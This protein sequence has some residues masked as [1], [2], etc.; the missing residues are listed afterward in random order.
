MALTQAKLRPTPQMRDLATE[1]AQIDQRLPVYP[2][3]L[4]WLLMVATTI[5]GFDRSLLSTVLEDV[6]RAFDLNDGQLGLLTGAYSVLAAIS[7]LPFGILTDRV[8]RASLVAFGFVPWGLGMMWQGVAQSFAMMFA[9]RMFLGLLE[10]SNVPATVVAP[11]RLLPGARAQPHLRSG[12]DRPDRRLRRRSHPGW[13]HRVLVGMALGV[14]RL[15]PRRV[16]HGRH[17]AQVPARAA[18]W[19]AGRQVPAAEPLQGAAPRADPR[20]PRRGSAPRARARGPA[21]R[22]RPVAAPS[23]GWTTAGS[24]PSRPPPSSCAPR[25]CG[26]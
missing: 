4:M 17:R 19:P 3:S 11:R 1:I 22:R 6:R 21:R 7:V 18:A 10:A 24:P 9:A 14:R 26:S 15:G 5:D 12:G 20:Q 25:P 2:M 8:R 13:S 16:L 23:P